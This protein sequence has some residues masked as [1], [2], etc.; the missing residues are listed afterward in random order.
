MNLNNS[1]LEIFVILFFGGGCYESLTF[2]DFSPFGKG[3]WLD[4]SQILL[5]ALS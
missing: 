3:E 5:L 1:Y 4:S 2:K